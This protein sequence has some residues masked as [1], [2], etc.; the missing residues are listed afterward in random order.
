MNK[1]FPAC[2]AGKL[3]LVMD[4]REW[5]FLLM[6]LIYIKLS[7]F[8]LNLVNYFLKPNRFSPEEMQ[9]YHKSQQKPQG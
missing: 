9:G 5:L 6:Q 4:L 8:L 7:N 3:F 2:L 1:I